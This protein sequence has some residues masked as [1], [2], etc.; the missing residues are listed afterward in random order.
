LNINRKD[1][2]LCHRPANSWRYRHPD[3]YWQE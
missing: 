3:P 1:L 2:S